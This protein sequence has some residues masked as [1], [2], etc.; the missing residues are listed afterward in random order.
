M[1]T[2]SRVNI[3]VSEKVNAKVGLCSIIRRKWSWSLFGMFLL[4]WTAGVQAELSSLRGAPI[5]DASQPS[6]VRDYID[7]DKIVARS[8]VQQP[9]VI[10]HAVR[11][12]RVN[13]R[14]NRCLSCHAWANYRRKKSTKISLTHFR[15]RQGNELSNV[16]ASR[17]FCS[18]CHVAQVNTPPLVGNRFQPV[19]ALIPRRRRR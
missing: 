8:F 5:Q 6:I 13:L 15:D 19:K 3:P 12:Y 7:D 4:L 2:V 1:N 14:E 11:G 10:P 18:Q 16:A 17:Y 9:P